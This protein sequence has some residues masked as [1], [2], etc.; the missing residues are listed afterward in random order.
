MPGI[1]RVL[2]FAPDKATQPPTRGFIREILLRG[3]LAIFR[4]RQPLFRI[5]YGLSRTVGRSLRLGQFL[6][7]SFR[8][9]GDGNVERASKLIDCIQ[10][11]AS[12][13]SQTPATPIAAEALVT[14]PSIAELSA[15][16]HCQSS[17]LFSSA[18]PTV[19][20]SG[21]PNTKVT[22]TA[23]PEGEPRRAT[24]AL[25]SVFARTACTRVSSI[26]PANSVAA[27]FR[28]PDNLSRPS[29][30][31]AS[32]SSCFWFLSALFRNCLTTTGQGLSSGRVAAYRRASSFFDARRR[33]PA[34]R[35]ANRGV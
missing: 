2:D 19:R 27:P 20:I 22:A 14:S 9:L 15:P 34:R 10:P 12:F 32:S 8:A 6:L 31:T 7:F 25:L 23:T 21:A 1:I 29:C 28:L 35:F 4:G 17:A 3:D 5:C 24:N 11:I 33:A 18:R 26:R 30:S 13:L 16:S